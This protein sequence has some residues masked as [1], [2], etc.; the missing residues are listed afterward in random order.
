MAKSSLSGIF[1]RGKRGSQDVETEAVGVICL[2][3]RGER[4][5]ES[6]MAFSAFAVL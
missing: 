5:V 3:R 4:C 1:R 2:G 6:R